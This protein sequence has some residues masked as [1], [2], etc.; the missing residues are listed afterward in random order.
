MSDIVKTRILPTL[1]LATT[2]ATVLGTVGAVLFL[3][4][5]APPD[6]PVYPIVLSLLNT[7]ASAWFTVSLARLARSYY[8]HSPDVAERKRSLTLSGKTFAAVYGVSSAIGWTVAAAAFL[9]HEPGNLTKV[10]AG[11]GDFT[12]LVV[13]VTVLL[14]VDLL[15]EVVQLR[16]DAALTV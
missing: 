2:G 7:A 6:M 15:E 11:F 8:E 5:A 9:G 14:L 4:R 10:S 16:D 12:W 1:L 13:V 3:N